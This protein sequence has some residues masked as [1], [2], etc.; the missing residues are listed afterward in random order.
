LGLT[1]RGSVKSLGVFQ[2]KH[3]ALGD[4]LARRADRSEYSVIPQAVQ[5]GKGREPKGRPERAPTHK[6]T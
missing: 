3:P 6:A 5:A 1:P 2:N 4:S